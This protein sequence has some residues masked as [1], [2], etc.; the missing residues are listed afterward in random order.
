MFVGS[1]PATCSAQKI[2][3]SNNFTQS[4]D[5]ASSSRSQWMHQLAAMFPLTA[6]SPAALLLLRNGYIIN[7]I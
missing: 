7:N 2:P 5:P 4:R 6:A 3:P 1:S